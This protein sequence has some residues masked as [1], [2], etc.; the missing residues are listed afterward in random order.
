MEEPEASPE[1]GTEH[2]VG[3]R[4]IVADVEP[5]DVDGVRTVAVGAGLWLAGFVCLLP[6]YGRLQDDGRTWWLWACLAG[7]GLGLVGLAYCRHRRAV[8]ANAE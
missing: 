1:T 5:L 2:V 3:G 6:F 7:F 8:R 4:F